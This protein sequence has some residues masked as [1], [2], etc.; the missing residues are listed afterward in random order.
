MFMRTFAIA[1]QSMG[2]AQTTSPPLDSFAVGWAC[3]A[4]GEFTGAVQALMPNLS[5]KRNTIGMPL[6]SA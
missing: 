4:R 1:L 6:S 5:L 2:Y 3:P